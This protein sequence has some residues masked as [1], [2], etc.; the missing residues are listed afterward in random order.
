MLSVNAL[1]NVLLREYSRAEEAKIR[2]GKV[3]RTTFKNGG[4]WKMASRLNRTCSK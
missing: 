3:E 2:P 1:P 4:V